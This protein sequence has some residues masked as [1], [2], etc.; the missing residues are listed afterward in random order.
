MIIDAHVHLPESPDGADQLLRAADQVGIDKMVIFCGKSHY[1]RNDLVL[2]AAEKY[3]D[4]FIPFGWFLLGRD[5]PPLI[6]RLA[7]E[8]M[9]GIKFTYPKSDYNDLRYFPVYERCAERGLAGLFH[10]GIVARHDTD[11]FRD[12]D[13]ERMRPIALDRVM[14][15]F[16]DWNV[17]MA[18]MGNPWHDVAAMM[19]RW[20]R[21]LYSDLSGSTLKYRSPEYL[22][23]L[24]WWGQDPTYKDALGRVAFEKIVFGTDVDPEKMQEVY[25]D[26][27]RLFEAIDLEPEVRRKVMGLTAA[28]LLG[29]ETD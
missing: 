26:Y 17:I 4:R 1:S 21:N 19:L 22:R 24:L 6:D 3:P 11:R 8:G 20:H 10:T 12:I 5:E 29:I 7:D 28:S 16:T 23:G 2:A 27:Q 15:R 9:K 25:D 13:T 14:R 18:H